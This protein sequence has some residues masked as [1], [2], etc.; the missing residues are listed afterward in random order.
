[1]KELIEIV[2]L[3]QDR[4]LTVV[5]GVTGLSY[6]TVWRIA[7]GKTDNITLDTLKRLNDYFDRE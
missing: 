6:Q 3:L 2:H 5:A 7:R 1:M 4:N